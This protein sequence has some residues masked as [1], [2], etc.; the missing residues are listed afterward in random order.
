L[1]GYELGQV[2][3]G[4]A[5]VTLGG[6]NGSHTTDMLWHNVNSGGFEVYDIRNNQITNAAF[7]GTIGPNWQ[8]SA[9]ASNSLMFASR[10][11]AFL[12]EHR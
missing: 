8:Y 3:T 1:A 2:G 5:F 10:L 9:T 11:A 4:L 12:I 7:M 6:F